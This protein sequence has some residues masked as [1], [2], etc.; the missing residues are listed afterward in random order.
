SP[1]P[2]AIQS[3]VPCVGALFSLWIWRRFGLW[4]AFLAAMAFALF[5]PEYWTSSHTAQHVIVASL[6]ASGLIC[7]M[8]AR[9]HHLF[10]YVKTDYSIAEC[11]L[12]LGIYLAINLQLSSLDLHAR[13][14]GIRTTAGSEFARPFYWTTWVLT[15]CL[16]PVVLA[17]GIRTKDRY[18]IGVGAVAA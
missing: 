7:L 12:W 14:L 13:W 10:G 5:L 8:A 16:P 9:S 15:W 2:D 6:Y 3:L 18:V 11:L 1:K 17:R 4:Y